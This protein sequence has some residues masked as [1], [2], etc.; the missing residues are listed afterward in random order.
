MVGCFDSCRG[1]IFSYLRTAM[2]F[3]E[4]GEGHWTREERIQ[5]QSQEQQLF[6]IKQLHLTTIQSTNTILKPKM[7]IQI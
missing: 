6:Q 1:N 2:H 4:G 7:Q 5:I 3:T